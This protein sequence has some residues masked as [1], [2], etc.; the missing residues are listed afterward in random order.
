MSEQEIVGRQ[1]CRR[2]NAILAL[3]SAEAFAWALASAGEERDEAVLENRMDSARATAAEE[4][5]RRNRRQ[6]RG[7]TT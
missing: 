6:E 7:E 4:A 3:D 1:I 2:Q 5:E